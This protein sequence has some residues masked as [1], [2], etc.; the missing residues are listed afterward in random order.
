[1]KCKERLPLLSRIVSPTFLAGAAK[2]MK[3]QT[4]LFELYWPKEIKPHLYFSNRGSLM[5]PNWSKLASLA[6][7]IVHSTV[8]CSLV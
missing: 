3:Q 4:M 5:R 2:E 1:M 6:Q 7:K 8:F